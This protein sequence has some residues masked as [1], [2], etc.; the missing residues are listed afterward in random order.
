MNKR[1]RIACFMHKEILSNLLGYGVLI[2]GLGLL[3]GNSIHG[4]GYGT[5]LETKE[6]KDPLANCTPGGGGLGSHLGQGWDQ[7][8]LLL[9]G[10]R[11]E[12]LEEHYMPEQLNAALST[13]QNAPLDSSG[14]MAYEDLIKAHASLHVKQDFM[15]YF[16]AELNKQN[17][18]REEQARSN[19]G[20]NCT[21]CSW[22][23]LANWGSRLAWAFLLSSFCSMRFQ[24]PK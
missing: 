16:L 1:E 2:A 15:L 6:H 4:M 14:R 13:L 18:V 21:I 23:W 3:V 9:I 7:V 12:S 8:S 22:G 11:K 5:G 10:D 19:P 17:K 20:M 24:C